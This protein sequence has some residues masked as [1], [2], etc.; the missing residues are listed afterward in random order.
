ML[1]D[2]RT[3]RPPGPRCSLAAND[4][5]NIPRCRGDSDGSTASEITRQRN[6]PISCALST[7]HLLTVAHNNPTA[8]ITVTQAQAKAISC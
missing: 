8:R 1:R 3:H 6:T 7:N 2:T 5:T 4:R